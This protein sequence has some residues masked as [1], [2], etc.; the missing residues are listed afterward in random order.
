M[1]NTLVFS[2]QNPKIEPG[3]CVAWTSQTGVVTH[4]SS[5]DNCADTD[6]VCSVQ[7]P[8]GMCNWD[9]GNETA[10]AVDVCFYD[11]LIFPGATSDGFYCRFH[12]NPSH[13]LCNMFGTMQV[14]TPIGLTVGKDL[15]NGNILLSW[16]GG[17][18]TGDVTYRVVRSLVGDPRFT[19]GVNTVTGSPDGGNAG[20][21]FT[22]LG[23]LSDPASHYYLIRN[24]QTTEP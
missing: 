13:T 6:T 23:G 18:V 15:T 11:P 10:A 21:M 9:S 16:T 14:T 8:D 12:C 17:G 7:D 5:A 1:M 2:P 3:D 20:T 22:E 19:V 24:R 4:S